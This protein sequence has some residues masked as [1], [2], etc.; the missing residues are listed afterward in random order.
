[1]HNCVDDASAA[2]K[3]ALAKLDRGLDDPIPI[4]HEDVSQQYVLY[5]FSFF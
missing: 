3:L 5:L 4:V 2:M 1:M